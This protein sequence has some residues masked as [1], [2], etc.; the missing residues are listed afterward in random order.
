MNLSKPSAGEV[1]PLCFYI[2]P[3]PPQSSEMLYNP[4]HLVSTIQ[5][6]IRKIPSIKV[7]LLNA[8]LRLRSPL[9][10]RA[11]TTRP[12][13]NRNAIITR[14]INSYPVAMIQAHGTR[15]RKGLTVPYLRTF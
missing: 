13:I 10:A 12:C 4:N 11:F 1:A 7:W 2:N 8:L 6:L 15:R 14:L 9:S 3:S 5:P